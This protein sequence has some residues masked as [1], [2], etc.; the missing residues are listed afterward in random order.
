MYYDAH[1]IPEMGFCLREFNRE[2]T[3]TE[4]RK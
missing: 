1:C 2:K 3:F 4:V